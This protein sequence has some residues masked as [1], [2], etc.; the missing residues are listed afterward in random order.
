MLFRANGKEAVESAVAAYQA[1]ATCDDMLCFTGLKFLL[2]GGVE[3]AR[4]YEPYR[5]VEGE[6]LDPDYRG[7]MILP[8]GGISEYVDALRLAAEAG[9]QVQTHGVGDETLDVIVDAY[10][11]VANETNTPIGMDGLRWTVM[12]IFLPTEEAI[13]TMQEHDILASAQ[14]HP[15]LLGHNQL[16]WWGEERAAYAI[17]I[18]R[19]LE[20]GLVVGGGTDAPVVSPNPFLSLWWMVTRGTLSGEPLGPEQAVT[21]EEALR[22]WT[23]DSAKIQFAEDSRGSIEEG[24]LADFAVLSDDI[25]TIP[26]AEI[27]D[28]RAVLTAV[29]G[30]IVHGGANEL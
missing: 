20:A 16:R 26:A 18:N 24:K 23:M 19:L 10:E 22:M 11:T 4:L 9:F 13:A 17:P 28:L 12:H 7:V 29:G 15:V 2:D 27:R 30:R 21:I 8:P 14:D 6:Q 25:L 5:I 3:G 1:D